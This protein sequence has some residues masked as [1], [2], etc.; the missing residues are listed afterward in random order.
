MDHVAT[1]VSDKGMY[2][3][4]NIVILFGIVILF[5]FDSF[6]M[7]CLFQRYLS[8]CFH[9]VIR[10]FLIE[11]QKIVKKVLAEKSKKSKKSE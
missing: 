9:R 2:L 4:A 11:E 3:Q 10:A 8:C 7:L 1:H 6:G 5:S